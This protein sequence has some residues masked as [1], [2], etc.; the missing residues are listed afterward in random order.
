MTLN[1]TTADNWFHRMRRGEVPGAPVAALLGENIIAVDSPP[2]ELTARFHGDERFCNPAGSIQG[3]MLGAML[4]A[5]TAG[6]MDSTLQP[7]EAVATLGLQ[8]QF[9]APARPGEIQGR[10]WFTRRGRD[11]GFIQGELQQEGR[12][13]ATAQAICKVIKA[14][15]A[16]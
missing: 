13:V 10:A 15:K 4:D 5:L 12:T 2:G 1:P 8:L 3:G 14:N 16:A 7:G 11:I 9:L 6:L